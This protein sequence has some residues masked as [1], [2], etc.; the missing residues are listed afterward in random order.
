ALNHKGMTEI[1]KENFNSTTLSNLM[2]P[3]YL[4]DEKATKKSKDGMPVCTFENCDPALKFC[5]E[6][7]IK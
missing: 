2:K 1:L 7:G 5:Q 6:N 3:E 4:L